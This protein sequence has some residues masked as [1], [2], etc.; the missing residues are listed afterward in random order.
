V[1]TPIPKYTTP[2]STNPYNFNNVYTV[3]TKCIDDAFRYHNFYTGNC[4]GHSQGRIH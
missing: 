4:S 1:I 2:S 3:G